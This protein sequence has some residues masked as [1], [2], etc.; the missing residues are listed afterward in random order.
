MGNNREALTG[1][2]FVG[3]NKHVGFIGDCDIVT[4]APN[5]LSKNAIRLVASKCSL[6]ARIDSLHESKDGSSGQALKQ[7]ILKKL[8]KL[9]APPP[10]KQ[11]KAL[12][13]PITDGPKTRRGGRRMRKLKEIYATTELR[14]QQNRLAFGVAEKESVVNDS[15]QGFGMIGNAGVRA[16]GI[17]NKLKE[18]IKKSSKLPD[19]RLPVENVSGAPV[20][21]SHNEQQNNSGTA[22]S[23]SF[24]AV[25]GLELYNPQIAESAKQNTANKYFSDLFVFKQK[26]DK[27]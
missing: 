27:K 16:V 6:A 22:S 15:V 3:R 20:N 9:N 25:Q 21:R 7:E 5:D 17:N 11:T 1:Q 23:V 14:K 19:F 24:T 2:S 8:E 18:S 4:G 13:V 12:P 10:I 26:T